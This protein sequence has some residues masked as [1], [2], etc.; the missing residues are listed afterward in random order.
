MAEFT[1]NLDQLKATAAKTQARVEAGLFAK[2]KDED[3]TY[4]GDDYIVWDRT[5]GERLRRGLP[6]LTQIGYPRPP[7]DTTGESTWNAGTPATGTAPT[8]PDG[9]AKTFAIKGPPG[10]TREQ[11]FAIFKKQADTGSL[12]GFEPGQTLSAA[13]QAAD[14]LASAQAVVAQAQSAVTGSLNVGSLTSGLS[15]AGVDLASGRIPSVDAAF[16]KGGPN[17]GAGAFNSVLGSVASGLGAAGGALGGSLASIVP[18]LTAA[19]GP[20]VSS[21]SNIGT[22]LVGAAG[23]QGSTAI[24]SIETINKNIT[25]LPVTSPINTA[26]FTKIASGVTPAG[27]LSA[28]G[29][30]SVPEVNGVLA[31][32]KNL[33]G[34]A[35]TAL[36]NTKG[37]GEFGLN[38]GQLETAGYVKPGTRALLAAG[39]NLF[40]DVVKSPAV[41]TGKDGI[42]SATDLLKNVPKQSQ[43]QQD[44]MTKGVAG[45]AAVGV[46]VSSLSSQGIAGMALNAAKD[47]PSAEAFVK[48]LPIPGDATGALQAE[49]SSAV[50]DGAFAV[51]LVQTKIP[52]E[53]KQQDIPVPADNTVKRGT[54]DAASS[55]VIG[56][57]KV[58]P[59]NYGPRTTEENEAD[60]TA[61]V[62]KSIELINK[63]VNPSGR[64]LSAVKSKV[65][66]LA[67][68]QSITQQAYDAV[69]NEYQKIRQDYNSQAPALAGEVLAL[70]NRLTKA[71]QKVADTYPNSPAKIATL[72]RAGV[73]LSGQVKELLYTVSL[74][75][76]GRGEGE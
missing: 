30:M 59:P 72:V 22:A 18:G 58:P 56:D 8:N 32:A 67:N 33:V 55:R 44:L 23:I 64:A 13:T 36:S 46:P 53:F 73:E 34:Q 26:D 74:K 15:A 62:D 4:T 39:T 29:P 25:Q 60:V 43:I 14:G 11:A 20:A 49:F 7:E 69:N 70:Y 1:F 10:F 76:E 12:V 16:A 27:A 37:L 48:G 41:W 42:K 57:E 51:N 6:S 17:G 52:T 31:Q 40:A 50:R 21:I 9:T 45:L 65:E 54:L 19:V 2:T 24:K 5:N 61:Y 66:A 38:L 28:I 71:Q 3:L 47:L 35:S 68:Q 75:I 63:Y